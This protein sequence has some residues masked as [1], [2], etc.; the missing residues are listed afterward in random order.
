MGRTI[1]LAPSSLPGPVCLTC[2]LFLDL[3]M[4]SVDVITF[5]KYVL[6]PLLEQ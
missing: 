2:M 6:E 5:K 4:C 1:K 3:L